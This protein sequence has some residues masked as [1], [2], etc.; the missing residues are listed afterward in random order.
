[1][2][3]RILVAVLALST[4]LLYAQASARYR[5]HGQAVLQDPALTPGVVDGQLTQAKLCDP[6]FHTGSVRNVTDSQKVRV[7]RAYGITAGCLGKGYEIDHLVSIE[8]GGANDD[9]NLWPQPADAPGLIG[10]HTKDV[11]ENRAHRAVCEGKL[12]LSQ[13]QQGIR[14]D[15]YAF[16]LANGFIGGADPP[17]GQ[18]R[19]AAP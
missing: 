7:C 10:Y 17:K 6:A 8:L 4:G 9:G 19:T 1:M 11:V 5:H 15:W 13:A 14:T 3:V 16:G 18:K 2:R 12:T